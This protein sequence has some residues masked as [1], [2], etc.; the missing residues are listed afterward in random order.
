MSEAKYKV[1]DEV[2]SVC[3]P[4]PRVITRVLT[5][6]AFSDGTG[7]HC[8]SELTPYVRPL[9]VGD[10]VRATSG[11]KGV[12]VATHNGE[13]WVDRGKEYGGCNTY[14]AKELERIPTE[15]GK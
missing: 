13:Y 7:L 15:A 10:R 1:G 4:K 3:H 14:Q 6:Y 8:E 12:I 5:C 11:M 9:A 2:V